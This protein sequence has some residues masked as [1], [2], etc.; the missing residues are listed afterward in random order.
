[1]ADLAKQC[2]IAIVVVHHFAKRTAEDVFDLFNGSYGLN[3]AVDTLTVLSGSGDRAAFTAPAV[4][5]T[6]ARASR[7]AARANEQT[8]PNVDMRIMIEV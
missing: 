3:G 8:Q 1:M 7:P 2:G 4:D 6:P 5:L